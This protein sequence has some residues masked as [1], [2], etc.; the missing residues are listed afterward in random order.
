MEETQGYSDPCFPFVARYDRFASLF[1]PRIS[2]VPTG[3]NT[4]ALRDLRRGLKNR[5]LNDTVKQLSNS[6]QG[7]QNIVEPRRKVSKSKRRR[8][9]KKRMAEKAL[10]EFEKERKR[11]KF[12]DGKGCEGD[13]VIPTDQSEKLGQVRDHKWNDTEVNHDHMETFTSKVL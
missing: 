4:K 9:M 5:V 10:E 13:E 8:D 11:I 7:E 2:S 6:Q 12:G 1:V 3:R